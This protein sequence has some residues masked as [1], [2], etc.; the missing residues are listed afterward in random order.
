MST[1]KIT[2]LN[3]TSFADC[4]AIKIEYLTLDYTD[5]Y[6][7]NTFRKGDVSEIRRGKADTDVD[8]YFS[9]GHERVIDFNVLNELGGVTYATNE[10]FCNALCAAIF[11]A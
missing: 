5:D 10:L 7:S 8:I 4:T 3:G 2:H 9:S 1:V 11:G 6:L